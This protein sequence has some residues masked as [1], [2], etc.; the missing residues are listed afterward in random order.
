M[1][2]FVNSLFYSL[3]KVFNRTLFRRV[4]ITPTNCISV[5]PVVLKLFRAVIKIKVAIMAYYY[6]CRSEAKCRPFHL[7]NLRTKNVKLKIMF[8]AYFEV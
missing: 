5:K 3:Y 8:R 2:T 1:R 4:Q 6:Q 7:S